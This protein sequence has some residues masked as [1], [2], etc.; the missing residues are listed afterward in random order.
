LFQ[1]AGSRS[2]LWDGVGVDLDPIRV[3]DAHLT[4]AQQ[5]S[6]EAILKRNDHVWGCAFDDPSGEWVDGLRFQRIFLSDTN[7]T[8]LV[9]AGSGCASGGQG[10]N[11]VM[12]IVQL[13]DG[14]TTVLASPADHFSGY[15]FSVRPSTGSGYKD[16]V[17]GWHMVAS[18]IN[19]AYFRFEGTHYRELSTAIL[20]WNDSGHRIITPDDKLMHWNW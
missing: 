1:T 14:K 10:I 2:S 5:R 9:E 18:Q 4:A 20:R 3:G 11:H 8:I 12:W 17:L 19:L 6:I 15:L 7:E 16:I 13:A